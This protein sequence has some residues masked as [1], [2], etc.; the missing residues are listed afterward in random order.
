MKILKKHSII[1]QFLWKK[2]FEENNCIIL[3]NEIKELIKN[4]N[5]NNKFEPEIFEK[6]N[7]NNNH[8]NFIHACANLTA[9]NYRLKE[10]D[11]IKTRLIAGKIIPTV[12]TST[13]CITGFKSTQIFTLLF[14]NTI[15]SLKE[16]TI[17]LAVNMFYISK[18][19]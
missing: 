14:T 10:C 17:N 15:N 18:P 13:A 2:K 7:D 16:I 8:I 11:K 5:I 9:R 12:S 1:N 4:R 6:D 19:K 3:E